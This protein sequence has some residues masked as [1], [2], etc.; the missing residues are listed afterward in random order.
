MPVIKLRVLPELPFSF[1]LRI[2]P[3]CQIYQGLWKYL[4]E[5]NEICSPHR[6]IDI[7][8][9]QLLYDGSCRSL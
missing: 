6:K 4:R 1:N 3:S 9:E 5:H 7:F 8:R 2:R